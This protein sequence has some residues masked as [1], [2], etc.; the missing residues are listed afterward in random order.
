[1]QSDQRTT[2]DD[3][4][5]L[6]GDKVATKKDPTKPYIGL[7]QMAEGSPELIGTLPASASTSMNNVFQ[8]GDILFGKLRPNLRKSIQT[9]FGGYCSTDIL[10]LRAKSGLIPG[11]VA[12]LFQWEVVFSEAVRTAEGT[13]MPRTSWDKLR[14]FAILKHE[15]QRQRRIADILDAADAAI[16]QTEAVIAKLRQMRAGL[17]HDLLTRGLN[18]HINKIRTTPF[19]TD[20]FRE[21]NLGELTPLR[22]EK[23]RIGLPIM[24]VT[25]RDGLM[26]RD[27]NERRV[28]TQLL[29]TQHLLARQ[30]DIAYNMMRMWQ[31]ACGLAQ[32]DCLLSPA[33]V[34][35]RPYDVVPAFVYL[36]FK[37]PETIQK[38]H[39][40]SR[41]LTD[42]RLRLY[43]RDF[44]RIVVRIPKSLSEQQAIVDVIGSHDARIHTEEATRD[45]LKLQK[46]GLMNDLLTGR[47][48]V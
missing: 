6:I 33:Y 47:V 23:G 40:K 2:L 35:V 39:N 27:S 12:K 22:R 14:H 44:A 37:L 8:P 36:L 16:R 13:K 38:F 31:G 21:C 25:I 29:P 3:L 5:E 30:G 26:L 4:V 7:E 46:R 19:D 45:K 17:L 10:V 15:V 43:H 18:C 34:V 20:H 41:G 9:E 28:D 1:M 32:E 11:Y 48:R 24:A 42:D